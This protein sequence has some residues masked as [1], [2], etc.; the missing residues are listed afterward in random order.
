MCLIHEFM[1]S[2]EVKRSIMEA[3]PFKDRYS[4]N[5]D[6]FVH[7]RLTDAAKFNPGAQYYLDC[8]RDPLFDNLYIATDQPDHDIIRKILSVYPRASLVND[9]E[10]R[11]MQFGS[12]CKNVCLSHGS[13]SAI[14]G[15]LSFFS[16]VQYP[17]YI[18]DKIWH[19]DMFSVPGWIER[20]SVY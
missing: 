6:M 18:P 1:H 20:K 7:V 15:Y 3:N 8:L 2:E 5:N 17:T 4:R 14:I 12:T 16:T 11:T 10:V 19:G 9:D 13:F